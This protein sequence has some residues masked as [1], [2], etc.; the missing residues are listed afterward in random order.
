MLFDIPCIYDTQVI[1]AMLPQY[2]VKKNACVLM[3]FTFLFF[4]TAIRR[5]SA[6]YWDLGE[7]RQDCSQLS[8]GGKY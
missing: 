6:W 8:V 1:A 3:L 7:T 5:S 4:I 2:S